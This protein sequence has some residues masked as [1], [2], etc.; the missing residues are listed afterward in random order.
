MEEESL[1]IEKA[2]IT[3]LLEIFGIY[4]SAKDELNRIKIFQ[5]T[6]IY[7]TISVVEADINKGVL[8]TLKAENEI[9]GA[10]NINEEQDEAYQTINWQFNA[11]KVLVIHRLVVKPEQQGK[12]FAKK[13]M[14]FAEDFA[15]K[16]QYSVIRLDVYTQNK[17]AVKFYEKRNYFTRGNV[18]FWKKKDPFHCMEKEVKN[19]NP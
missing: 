19:E 14:D 13:L 12:G 4:K 6:D 7:P 16:N 9:I 5:W 10:I 17:K 15:V 2:K 18:F 8:Y 11:E 1:C 3:D